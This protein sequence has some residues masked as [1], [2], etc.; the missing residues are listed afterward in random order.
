MATSIKIDL[1]EAPLPPP[2][3]ASV[4]ARISARLRGRELDEQ[5]AVGADPLTDPALAAR[6]SWLRARWNRARIADGLD[7][8]LRTALEPYVLSAQAPFDSEAI[9][10]ARPELHALSA[11]LRDDEE[12]RARGVA[13]ARLL[14]VDPMSP[15][16]RRDGGDDSDAGELLGVLRTTHRA[17]HSG[18]VR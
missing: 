18:G 3:W 16:Y 5:L 13:M 10:A 9:I 12:V 14:L 6:A 11:E 4:R 15:L 8:A 2:R 17:L 7:R 1:R